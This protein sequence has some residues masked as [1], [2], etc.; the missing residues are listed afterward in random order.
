MRR[1]YKFVFVGGDT[2]GKQ[3]TSMWQS[4]RGKQRYSFAVQARFTS[5]R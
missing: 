1:D 4:G 2:L 5:A 3:K